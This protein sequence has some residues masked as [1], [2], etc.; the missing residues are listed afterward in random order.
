MGVYSRP[1][2]F[3]D[4][5]L[6]FLFSVVYGVR[7]GI[8][9]IPD[10]SMF[11]FLFRDCRLKIRRMLQCNTSQFILISFREDFCHFLPFFHFGSEIIEAIAPAS[12]DDSGQS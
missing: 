7:V 3:F 10:P 11:F 4:F 12:H 2:N 5:A 9:L 6:D 8:V 1:S